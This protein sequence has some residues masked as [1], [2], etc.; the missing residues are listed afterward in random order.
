MSNVLYKIVNLTNGKFY[1]GS[2]GDKKVRFQ[3]HRRLLR[4]G[5]HHCFVL[6]RAWDKYG[7]NNFH[8]MVIEEVPDTVELLAAEQVWLDEHHGTNYCYNSAKLA[9][10]NFRLGIKAPHSEET[11]Q[12]ISVACKRASAE[13]RKRPPLSDAEKE[14]VRDRMLGNKQWQGKHH[15]DESRAKMG[16]ALIEVTTGREF[17]VMNDAVKFYDMPN[18]TQI[19]RQMESGKPITRGEFKGLMFAYKGDALP[20]VPTPPDVPDEYADLPRDRATAKVTGAKQ[21]FTGI[22]CKRGH[23]SPRATKGTCIACR[24]EDEKNKPKKPRTAAQK[25]AGKRYYEKNK[26]AVK[27]KAKARPIEDQRKYKADYKARQ[28][29]RVS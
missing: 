18:L 28:K 1:V 14:A 2:T 16:K 5:K 26:E 7:E 12:K 24:R 11:K 9:G 8:F 25:A 10:P 29:A 21:Y 15:S 20:E 13:G 27:A 22:P 3:I 19:Y 23:V 6:Q 4:A 17:A